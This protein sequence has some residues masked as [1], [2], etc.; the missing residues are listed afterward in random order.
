MKFKLPY[1]LLCHQQRR[2]WLQKCPQHVL[3][4]R[5]TLGEGVLLPL[6]NVLSYLGK[7]GLLEAFQSDLLLTVFQLIM[8]MRIKLFKYLLNNRSCLKNFTVLSVYGKAMLV[9]ILTVSSE[10]WSELPRITQLRPAAKEC[11]SPGPLCSPCVAV[12]WSVI[13]RNAYTDDC[14]KPVDAPSNY[15]PACCLIL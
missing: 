6:F 1:L 9:L 11:L 8:L 15:Q 5:S 2:Q 10:Q 3:S 13:Y 14:Q 7:K 12:T 4:Y